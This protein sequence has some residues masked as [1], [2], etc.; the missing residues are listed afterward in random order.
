MWIAM[1]TPVAV[2]IATVLMER[3]ERRFRLAPSVEA[4]R[5]PARR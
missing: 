1:S 2:L 5:H 3:F 4:E